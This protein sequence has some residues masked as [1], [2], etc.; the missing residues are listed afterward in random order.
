MSAK[1]M[2]DFLNKNGQDIVDAYGA[3]ENAQKAGELVNEIA[4]Q[5]SDLQQFLY[6]NGGEPSASLP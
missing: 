1:Q 4:K 2:V 3:A 5:D 6:E